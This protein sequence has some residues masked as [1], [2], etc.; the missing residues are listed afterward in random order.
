MAKN[1]LL[2]DYISK[3]LDI[4]QIQ[5]MTRILTKLSSSQKLSKSHKRLTE[6]T[7][8]IE[9]TKDNYG[10]Y[11]ELHSNIDYGKIPKK[12]ELLTISL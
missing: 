1:L 4:Q 5:N 11:E 2:D 6:L 12:D 3:K 8:L 10:F 7:A 9:G